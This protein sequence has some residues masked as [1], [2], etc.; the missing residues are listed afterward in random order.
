[1]I[2]YLHVKANSQNRKIFKHMKSTSYMKHKLPPLS[3]N[4]NSLEPFID[5]ETMKVHHEKHHQTYTDKFNE[6]IKNNQELQN[7]KVEDILSNLNQIPQDIKQAV[8]NHGGGF[9]NHNFF[10]TILKKDIKL[11]GDILKEITKTFG[12]FETF[13]EQFTKA[14][15]T[16]FG[17]GWAWLVL[18]ENKKLE[19]IQTKNQDCPLSIKK[20]PLLAIDVWEHAYY[21]KYKN[22]RADYIEAFYNV[23]NWDKV[24][25]LFVNAK[26]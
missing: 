1:V 6:A 10:W 24:N 12:N 18:N 4:Y 11:K 26:K 25:E 16:L 2:D 14:A 23:I 9:Y 13:K 20:I 15:T 5:E 19:I 22:K 17:S 3:Y 8:I 7:K 21:L